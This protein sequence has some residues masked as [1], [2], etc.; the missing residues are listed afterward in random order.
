LAL[1]GRLTIFNSLERHGQLSDNLKMI[2]GLFPNFYLG[3]GEKKSEL[4]LVKIFYRYLTNHSL[5]HFF[6]FVNLQLNMWTHM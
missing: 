5:D 2:F 1:G 3:K 6:I 4:F